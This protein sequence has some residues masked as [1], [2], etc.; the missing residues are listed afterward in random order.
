MDYLNYLDNLYFWGNNGWQ[1]TKLLLIFF[2]LLLIT[3]IFQVYIVAKLKK[4]S[5]KTKTDIDDTV[6]DIFEKLKPPFYLLLAFYFA[7]KSINLPDLLTK[8]VNVAFIVVVVYKII[9]ALEKIGGYVIQKYFTNRAES[10]NHQE[11]LQ[12]KEIANVFKIV[13]RVVLWTLGITLALANMGVNVTSLIASLGI[14]GIAIA[15][16]LQNILGDLFSSF[17]LY[18][19]KPFRVGDFIMIGEHLGTVE[20][21]GLKTTR[22]R[23]LSGEQLVVSNN[24]LT[25]S[26]IQNFGRMQKR[27][28]I[29][30][31]GVVYGTPVDKLEKIPKIIKKVIQSQ[32]NAEFDRCHFFEYG[33]FS[34]NYE[35]VFYLTSPDYNQYMDTRQRI[36]LEI[37]K[38][39]AEEKIEFAYPTQTVVLSKT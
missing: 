34:L 23:S 20:K 6:I 21:I 5:V 8:T 25:S 9:R 37:Y 36:N 10:V 26:R 22:I 18:L 38:I 39:F 35:T 16:A 3:K 7:I 13:L 33:D 11:K 17:S 12:E 1:Y 30:N 24:E 15:L 29:F 31:I 32:S 4:L 28:V 27:R 14:G 19:D 2:G